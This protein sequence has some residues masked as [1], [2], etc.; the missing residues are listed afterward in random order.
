MRLQ[1]AHTRP[2]T[3]AHTR[4]RLEALRRRS[5]N[6]VA[7]FAAHAQAGSRLMPKQLPLELYRTALEPHRARGQRW[8]GA[9]VQRR[10]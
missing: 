1:A 8:R 9:S 10:R 3:P 2:P 4:H 6:A 7:F 5:P